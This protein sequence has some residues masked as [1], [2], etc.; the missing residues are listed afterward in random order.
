[1]SDAVNGLSSK[2]GTK[3]DTIRGIVA[4]VSPLIHS[5]YSWRSPQ[6]PFITGNGNID[7]RRQ[8]FCPD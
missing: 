8:L 6:L 4:A 2:Y 3:T 7:I 1:M 5:L